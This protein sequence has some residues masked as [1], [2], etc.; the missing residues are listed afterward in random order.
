MLLNEKKNTFST[1]VFVFYPVLCGS[2]VPPGGPRVRCMCEQPP[3][4]G[5][6]HRFNLWVSMP[7]RLVKKDYGL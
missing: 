7:D 4:K 6:R 5:V 1:Q 2:V 3:L